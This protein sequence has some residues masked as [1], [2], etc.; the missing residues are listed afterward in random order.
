MLERIEEIH[1]EGLTAIDAAGSTDALEELRVRL[2]GRKAELPNL[3][4][5][6]GELPPEQRGQVGKRANEVRKALEA[7]LAA[8]NER[9]DAAELD[10]RLIADRVDITLPGD[11]LQ[12]V[13]RLHLITQTLREL[14]DVF[15]GLGFTVVEG[16]EVETVHYNFDALNHDATHPARD[17]TDTFYI[18]G[19]DDLVLRTHTSPMQVRA[20]EAQPPPLY[21]VIPGRVYRRDSDA[22]HTPQFHQVEGLAVDEDITLA[23]L[24]GTLLEFSRA[25]FGDERDVRLRG[26]FFPF[27]EP[28]VEID[29]SCFNCKDGYLRDG[30]RC[31]LCRGEA[32]IEILGAGEVDPNVYSYVDDERYDP[33]KVQG[34]A[35]GMGIERIAF[36]K[37][38]V[39]DLRLFYENDLRFLEQFG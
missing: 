12:P 22:T 15:V 5:G 30:S 6:V 25:I 7:R 39:A 20:M 8:A 29:V 33:E 27:T 34:F 9:L 28:S 19:R 38:G 18:A 26:H 37:H 10:S 31:P 32:W 36:L 16:N 17:K 13:G 21:V 1:E 11:P 3:L 14:E 23:D 2:L 24:K 4:R 35:W